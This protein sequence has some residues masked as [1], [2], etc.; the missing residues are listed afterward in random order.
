[1]MK[2]QNSQPKKQTMTTSLIS[3]I[4]ASI[5]VFGIITLVLVIVDA[6]HS[7]AWEWLEKH[8]PD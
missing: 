1:M 4:T 5:T 3:V 7:V 6:L 2:P 8:D